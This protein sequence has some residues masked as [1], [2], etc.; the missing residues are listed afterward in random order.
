MCVKQIYPQP[1]EPPRRHVA[2]KKQ[3]YDRR[4]AESAEADAEKKNILVI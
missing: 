1:T 2:R 4:G 3:K